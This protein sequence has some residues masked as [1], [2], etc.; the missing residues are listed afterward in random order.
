MDHKGIRKY[1]ERRDYTTLAPL[2]SE[3]YQDGENRQKGLPIDLM[4]EEETVIE[5]PRVAKVPFR[6]LN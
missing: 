3:K 1:R 5:S 6:P 4:G 2:A